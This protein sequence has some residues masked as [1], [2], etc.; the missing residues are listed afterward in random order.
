MKDPVRLRGLKREL[1]GLNIKLK[2]SPL[3]RKD[4]DKILKQRD[5][6]LD[7]VRAAEAVNRLGSYE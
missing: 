2:R 7:L 4:Y 1:N 6:V 3:V 5:K